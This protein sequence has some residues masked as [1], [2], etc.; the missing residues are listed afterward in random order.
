MKNSIKFKLFIGIISILLITTFIGFI[1]NSQ[2]YKKYY[3]SN[4]KKEL[5]EYA[6][7]IEILVLNNSDN[8]DEKINQLI[9]NNGINIFIADINDMP[10]NQGK[11]PFYSQNQLNGNQNSRMRKNNPIYINEIKYNIYFN[12]YFQSNYLKLI[13]PLENNKFIIIDAPIN[14]INTASRFNLRFYLYISIFTIILG[15]IFAYMFAKKFTKPILKLNNQ[16]KNISKLNFKDKFKT[17]SKDEIATLGKNINF[18]SNK[19][20]TTIDSLN[21]DIKEKERLEKLR[22]D[23]IANISHE[24]KTPIA[25]IRNYSEG[26]LYDLK[27][28]KKEKYLNII[29][30]ETEKMN[31]LVMDILNL[32]DLE[33]G[34][35]KMNYSTFDISALID[36]I[37]LKYNK[38]FKDE[39]INL[40]IDKDDIVKITADKEKIE[41]VITNYLNNALNHID[42][43]KQL[44][45]KLI[46]NKDNI[47]FEIFNSGNN[48]N[49]KNKN[50]IWNKFYKEDKSRKR[51]NNSTGLGLNIVKTILNNH[52]DSKFGF[53]N[54]KFG[55]TFYF[56]LKK[57][58]ENA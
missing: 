34:K 38:I 30:D 57:L 18:L 39:K 52:K 51:I 6:K 37:C 58:S 22:K 42:N 21:E 26:L 11:N 46:N 53:K 40:S 29:I 3:I 33:S 43:K 5:L 7:E 14:I 24:F 36:E 4:Q 23:L 17:N 12:Q 13:Y 8:L 44:K 55:V 25:I 20:K 41:K 48:I 19:L 16:A 31:N 27:K 54:K 28:E 15:G 32:S 2:L 50:N 1:I 45:I 56:E 35:T 49:E 10:L 9:K 47:R